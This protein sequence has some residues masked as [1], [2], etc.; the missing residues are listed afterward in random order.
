MCGYPAL[1]GHLIFP[2]HTITGTG[3][4]EETQ[5]NKHDFKRNIITLTNPIMSFN[6]TRNYDRISLLINK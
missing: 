1:P 4:E 2:Q 6:K 3:W 5:T